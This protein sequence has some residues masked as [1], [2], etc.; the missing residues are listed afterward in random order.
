[1]NLPYFLYMAEAEGMTDIVNTKEAKINAAARLFQDYSRAGYNINDCRIQAS[2]F[3]EVGL[4]P[5]HLSSFDI[6]NLTRKVES[7]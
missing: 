6:N 2:I 4:D 3:D 7:Y 5:N 1:M